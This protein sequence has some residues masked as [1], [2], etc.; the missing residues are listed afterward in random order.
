[1]DE[2]TRLKLYAQA[3]DMVVQDAP[4]I[5]VYFQK[6]AELINPRVKGIRNSSSGTCTRP[7]VWSNQMPRRPRTLIERADQ[8]RPEEGPAYHPVD[9][10]R[11][12]R[13]SGLPA[14]QSNGGA[15]RRHPDRARPL[16]FECEVPE[17]GGS[18][19]R[20]YLLGVFA[21]HATAEAEAPGTLGASLQLAG[22]GD[23]PVLRQEL[24]NGRHYA[25]ARCLEPLCRML[26]DG[27]SLETAGVCEIG[28]ALARV[29]L[30]TFDVPHGI[31]AR[32]VRF[33]DLG[34]PA[35]FAL[36]DVFFEFEAPKGCPFRS[37]GG[38]VPLS[39]LGAVVRVGDRVRFH[40]AL[41]GLESALL[42]AEDLDEARGQALTF[43]AVATAA[44]LEM[45]GERAM[46]LMTLEAAREMD[47]VETKGEIVEV[48][49][50]AIEEVTASL[51]R[52]VEGSSSH[53]V[54][55]ALAIVERNF[56]RDL[57]DATVAAQLGLSTSHFRFLFRQTTG[58][59]FHRYLV[60]L[61]LEKARRML[62]EGDEPVSEVARAVGFAGLSHFSRAFAL[63]F[64]ASPTAIRRA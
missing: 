13:P 21:L 57:N 53:L 49:R 19:L 29:D 3:E 33:K 39:E 25:D 34:S 64:S 12:H 1:M 22:E 26:G 43:L 52:P 38:S 17:A 58:Q 47:R 8:K 59:P 4:F 36:F 42:E 44:T 7:R 14:W 32:K 35:S 51:F 55:R 61:R 45:G 27:T 62:V 2:A 24:L 46:H 30:L 10:P 9:P 28:G 56:A 48:A 20:L 54:D 50:R 41:D 6:D 60:N 40:K 63:R 18:L 23:R 15:G 37:G 5:P 31:A 11:D 16:S